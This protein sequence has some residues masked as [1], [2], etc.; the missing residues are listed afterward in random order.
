MK[1]IS[2]VFA[3]TVILLNLSLASQA[4]DKKQDPEKPKKE[5]KMKLK[6]H[7][8]TQACHDSGKHVYAHGEK[9]HVCT[10]ACKK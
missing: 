3:A 10:D 1:S 2:K 8:C 6:E 5:K 4:Q 9:G 7:V